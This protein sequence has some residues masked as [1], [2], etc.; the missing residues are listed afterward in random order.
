MRAP[1][2]VEVSL[3]LP[4]K[5]LKLPGPAFRGSLRLCTSVQIPQHGR[6]RPPAL[7]PQLK[8]DPLGGSRPAHDSPMATSFCVVIER[9]ALTLGLARRAL[10][11]GAP[12]PPRSWIRRAAPPTGHRG[13]RVAPGQGVHQ[14]AAPPRARRRGAPRR[15]SV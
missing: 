12:P 5:R 2:P 1:Q 10:V 6:L 7:A 14:S 9:G 11:R 15:V 3:A 8:R 4:N 13:A